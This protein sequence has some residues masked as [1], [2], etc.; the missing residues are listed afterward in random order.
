V[1]REAERAFVLPRLRRSFEDARKWFRRYWTLGVGPGAH[2][3]V[4]GVLNLTRE[5]AEAHTATDR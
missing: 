4:N 3:V 5:I 2:I 1:A